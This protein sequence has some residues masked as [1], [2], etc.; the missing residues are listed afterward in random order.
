MI[1]KT[2][3]T[4]GAA[5]ALAIGLAAPAGA[6]VVNP[7]FL[8]NVTMNFGAG[9]G[10]TGFFGDGG[11]AA[12]TAIDDYFL[13]FSPP[14]SSQTGFEAFA[15]VDVDSAP[16]FAL[17][18][19]GFG[20]FESAAY[21]SDG[22]F[23]GFDFETLQTTQTFATASGSA[24]GAKSANFLDSGIYYVEIEGTVEEAGGGF[25]GEIDTTPIPE[26]ANALLLLAGLG[27]MGTLARRRR[28]RG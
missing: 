23:A 17:T 3:T 13:Y 12:G 11:Y 16:T 24:L 21:D 8:D 6:T 28:M 1:R 4:L 22:N 10:T 25:Y 19:Y 9:L 14:V 27:A 18:G 7:D 5:S 26:P 2:L 15:D 20:V